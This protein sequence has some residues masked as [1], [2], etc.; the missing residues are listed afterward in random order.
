MAAYGIQEA[1]ITGEADDISVPTVK[2][3]IEA[4]PELV[5][6]YKLEDIWNMDELGIFFKL[7]PDKVLIEKAK[8][9][10]CWKRV[11]LTAA[12]FVNTDVQN[13]DEPVVIWKSK[14]SRCF[15]NLTDRDLSQPSLFLKRKYWMNIEILSEML[16]RLDCKLKMQ[17]RNVLLFLDNATSPTVN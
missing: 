10:K 9:Q 6:S 17:N 14:T 7:V 5:S 1:R 2:A 4:I 16:K 12:Y 11:R 8:S 3:W 13:V 15:R